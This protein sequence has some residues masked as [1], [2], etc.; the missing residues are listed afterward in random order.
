MQAIQSTFDDLG[1]SLADVTFVVV[2]LETTGGAPAEC[3]ITEI[4]AVK[5]RGGEHLGEFQTLV[6]PGEPIPAFISVLTGI[7]DGMVRDAPRIETALPAFLEFAAGSVLVAHNAGFDIG[8]LKAAAAR[9]G[10]AWPGFAVLDTLQL[11]RQLVVRDEAPN[12][13]LG[14]L[15]Q[16]FGATTTPDHRALHDARATVDVLHGLIE[17]VGNLGV[18]TLEELASYSSRVTPTQRRKRFLADPLP[19]APGVYLF[20]DG[21]GRVL[22]VGTSRDIRTRV[23][24][25]F[26]ASEQRS[27]MAE[28]VR[29]AQAVHPVVCQTPLEAQVRELRLI[30]EHKPR[31]NRR[32]KDGRKTMWVKLTS[33]RFPR[34]SIVKQVRDDDA[35]YIGPFRSRLT[36]QS[37]I[38]AVHE[39]VPLRQCTGRLSGRS[40]ACALADMGRCGAPCTGAQSEGDYAIVVADCAAIFSGNARPGSDLL[41]ARLEELASAERFEDAARVRDRFLQLVRG[42]ARAQR[43]APLTRSP[44]I[45]AARRADHGGWELVSIRH[46]RLAGTTVSPRG[47]DPMVYVR[48]LQATAEVVAPPTPDRPSALVEETELLLRWLEAPGV[49]IVELDG[50]WTCPV[51]GA[52]AVRHELE[53]AVAA[54]RDV[55]GFDHDVPAAGRR[56]GP[57]PAG[58]RRTEPA[59][60]ATA[61]VSP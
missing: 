41:R 43:L 56:P 39:V 27:R 7:T 32:S 37:A 52:G 11:A 58:P 31:F 6:D 57:R 19:H 13:R 3:G 29:L 25:Y 59:V 35:H 54:A 20:K 15:A 53:P 9:T 40:S 48:T 33:E 2:D 18:R 49:R 61:K 5:V 30:D 45:V 34:L 4:G 46:G 36:A 51:G 24:S 47:A 8:F 17:R 50:T 12:H 21:N 26:T 16:V 10:T 22:Y 14:S 23:R 1:T 44:E 38:D 42:A 55:V 60:V 28:M